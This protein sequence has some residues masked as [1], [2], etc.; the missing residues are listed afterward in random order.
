M[1]LVKSLAVILRTHML[2]E[3]SRVVVCYTRDYGKVRL[4]AKGVRKG[5]G[6]LGAALEPMTVSGVVFYLREGRD[7]SLVSQAEAEHRWPALRRDVV[8]MAY[9]GAV[10]ELV[11]ALVSEREPDPGIFD[12]IVR[13]LGHV[14]QVPEPALDGVLWWFELALATL[15]GYGPH[16]ERCVECGSEAGDPAAFAPLLGGVVCEACAPGHRRPSE[17]TREGASLLA[18]LAACEEHA[19]GGVPQVSASSGRQAGSPPDD[20]PDQGLAAAARATA[21]V[22]DEVNKS[23]LALFEA[24]SGHRLRLKSMSFLAQVRRT[25]PGT[26]ESE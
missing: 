1:A 20:P 5:G 21:G 25:E 14:A 13:A 22:R 15:L 2:G 6:P 24:H 10:L 4:V 17:I 19:S 16:L 8:R 26:A 11:D 9:A 7:L 12:L 23:M 18:G 3:T